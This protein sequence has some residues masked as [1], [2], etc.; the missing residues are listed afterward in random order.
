MEGC[1]DVWVLKLKFN[2]FPAS[3]IRRHWL[4]WYSSLLPPLFVLKWEQCFVFQTSEWCF[5]DAKTHVGAKLVPGLGLY[6][7]L[8]NLGK[9]VLNLQFLAGCSSPQQ[10]RV[11]PMLEVCGWFLTLLELLFISNSFLRVV[12]MIPRAW[13]IE[14]G[15]EKVKFPAFIKKLNCLCQQLVPYQPVS[16]VLP[17]CYALLLWFIFDLIS[18]EWSFR[19][20]D[21][22]LTYT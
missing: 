19:A 5:K 15:E 4:L 9:L 8:R 1:K 20:A 3:M 10:Q 17:I 6:L 11:L 12:R 13:I 7:P 22:E 14:Q 16:L 18:L 2:V 21:P